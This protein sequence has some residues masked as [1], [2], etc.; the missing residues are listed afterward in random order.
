ME[1]RK[2]KVQAC[3]LSA[4]VFRV[5]SF[6]NSSLCW[7]VQHWFIKALFVIRSNSGDKSELGSIISTMLKSICEFVHEHGGVPKAQ[8]LPEGS[9]CDLA[10]I[11]SFHVKGLLYEITHSRYLRKRK[12]KS[13]RSIM[14]FSTQKLLTLFVRDT[15]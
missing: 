10:Q 8:D 6:R 7:I 3:R 12:Y 13:F 14:D 11:Q 1:T 2:T 4:V 15:S 5:L 9:Y